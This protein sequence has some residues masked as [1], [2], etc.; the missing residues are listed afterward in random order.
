MPWS[1]H[2]TR[3]LN[4]RILGQGLSAG[5][6]SYLSEWVYLGVGAESWG[7]CTLYLSELVYLGIG[8]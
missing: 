7:Y 5:G 4:G 1:P 3:Q 8:G 6:T 2:G